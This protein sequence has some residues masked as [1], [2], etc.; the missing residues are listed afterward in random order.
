MTIHCI[1]YAMRWEMTLAAS[2]DIFVFGLNKKCG[3][4]T[5][6]KHTITDYIPEASSRPFIKIYKTYRNVRLY[7]HKNIDSLRSFTLY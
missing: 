6:S 4:K 7:N 1:H 5:G 3:G 2:A